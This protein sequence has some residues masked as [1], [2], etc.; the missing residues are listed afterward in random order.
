MDDTYIVTGYVLID[1]LLE[2]IGHQ[3]NSRASMSAAEV[4][5]VAVVAAKY[6]QNH[7][8][9]ALCLMQRLGYIAKFSVSRFNRRLHDLLTP[10]WQILNLLGD[11]LAQSTVYIID[12]MPMPVC[13]LV[14]AP[15]CKKVHGKPFYGYCASKG[16]HYFGWQLHLICDANGV[17]FRFQVLPARWDELVP[18]QE[19]LADLPEGSQVVADKGYISQKDEL[20]VYVNGN[21]RLIP[22]YRKNMRGNSHNDAALIREHRSIIET[23]NSQ[24]EKMGLQR[25]H[26]RTN[27]GVALKV[28][29][30]L[31]ALT[32]TNVN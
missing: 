17:P 12:T 7:H 23:V 10:F 18:V 9:R 28:L 31:T 11:L 16:E 21:V 15:R 13:K 2:L 4:I 8:E 25:I 19:L 24:L 20:M 27:E 22:K 32:L 14:R 3:D 5:T 6:F 29:A 26:A 30:S 1:D